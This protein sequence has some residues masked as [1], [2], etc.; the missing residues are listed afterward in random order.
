MIRTTL[1]VGFGDPTVLS[2]IYEIYETA[3]SKFVTAFDWLTPSLLIGQH[4]RYNFRVLDRRIHSI[5]MGTCVEEAATD[6]RRTKERCMY[7]PSSACIPDYSHHRVSARYC[8]WTARGS[9][10]SSRSFVSKERAA[11]ICRR[12][13]KRRRRNMSATLE[14]EGGGGGGGH[15]RFIQFSIYLVIYCMKFVPTT[16]SDPL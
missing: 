14:L 10:N 8:Y 15:A 5:D 11:Y 12:V 13:G 2:A 1:F 7:R 4:R 6:R 16:S 3:T 9:S